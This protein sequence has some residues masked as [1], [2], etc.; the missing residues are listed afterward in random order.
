[1]TEWVFPPKESFIP[2]LDLSEDQYDETI[3]KFRPVREFGPLNLLDAY[4]AFVQ[5]DQRP[6]HSCVAHAI[7]VMLESYALRQGD[8][9]T[10]HDPVWMHQCVAGL[11]CGD[12]FGVTEMMALLHGRTL[13]V[14]EPGPSACEYEDGAPMPKFA[15]LY[16]GNAFRDALDLGLA[17][18]TSHLVDKG[19]ETY[20]GGIYK[21]TGGS[22]GLHAVSIIG[23]DDEEQTWLCRNSFGE[24]WGEDG[25]FRAAYRTLGLAGRPPGYCVYD[26][27][28]DVEPWDPASS[29]SM[30]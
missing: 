2:E 16:K 28:L 15:Q 20:S 21:I 30:V 13:P 7:A 9:D 22:L 6:C 14:G 12:T 5:R 11:N 24:G 10:T 17:V 27:A 19:F 4:G 8:G 25:N 23:Y 1:M 29:D 18:A 3:E 26:P